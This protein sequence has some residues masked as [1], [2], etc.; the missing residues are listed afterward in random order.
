MKR[1]V[2]PPEIQ[3]DL[4]YETETAEIWDRRDL[5][6]PDEP[7]IA[8]TFVGI[9]EHLIFFFVHKRISCTFN[10]DQGQIAALEVQENSSSRFVSNAIGIEPRTPQESNSSARGQRHPPLQDSAC[11]GGHAS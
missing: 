9:E 1:F 8:G 7:M 11:C 3:A 6:E 4:A 2:P 5:P 10:A